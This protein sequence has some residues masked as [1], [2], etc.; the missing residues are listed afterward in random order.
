MSEHTNIAARMREEHEAFVA[1]QREHAGPRS[2]PEDFNGENGCYEN[3]CCYCR[4]P[5]LGHKR[6]VIC[7]VCDRALMELL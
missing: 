4:H 2:W 1:Y 7:K 3:S 5:F 6:R